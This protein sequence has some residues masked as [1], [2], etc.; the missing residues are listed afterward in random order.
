MGRDLLQAGTLAAPCTPASWQSPQL[1]SN[2]PSTNAAF[3][4]RRTKVICD[5]LEEAAASDMQHFLPG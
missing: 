1:P 4:H 3:G 2:S 5:L